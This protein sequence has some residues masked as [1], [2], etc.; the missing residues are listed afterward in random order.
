MFINKVINPTIHKNVTAITVWENNQFYAKVDQ[1]L[2]PIKGWNDLRG[3]TVVYSLPT[4]D[5]HTAWTEK[6]VRKPHLHDIA[7]HHSLGIL[8]WSKYKPNMRIKGT[9]KDSIFNDDKYESYIRRNSKK[10]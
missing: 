5:Y 7:E 3:S 8:F 10:S 6:P 2:Y 4:N 9:I 1:V